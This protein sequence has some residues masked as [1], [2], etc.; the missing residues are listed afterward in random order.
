MSMEPKDEKRNRIDITIEKNSIVDDGEGVIRFNGGLTL[1]DESSQ[2][3]GTRYDIASMDISRYD[4]TV[5]ADHGGMEGYS[6]EK[7]VGKAFGVAKQGTRLIAEG[8]RFAIK[9]SALAR[10]TYDMA[11]NG[12][13]NAV[14]IG[15]FGPLDD[16]YVYRNAVLKEFSFVGLGNNENATLNELAK[17]AIADAES[18]GMDT[19]ELKE[20][21]KKNHVDV[22]EKQE[23][24][25]QSKQSTMETEEKVE[26]TET[27][28]KVETKEETKED[29][30]DQAAQNKILE[31][32]NSL[33]TKVAKIEQNR[34]DDSAEEP[35][36][37]AVPR[38]NASSATTGLEKMGWKDITQLQV[39][40]FYKSTKGD[41]E[42][43]RKLN[44][45]N[46][47][48]F[49][50]L[51]E[52]NMVSNVLTME[53]FGNFVTN[54]ELITTIQ[55]Y[56]SNYSEF[57]AAFPY[58]QTNSLE[59]AWLVRDGDIDMQPVDMCDDGSSGN[60]KPISEYGADVKTKSLEELAA[61]TPVC[62]A[63]TIF[64]AA[65]LLE[66]AG[67]GYRNSYDRNKARGLVAA[68][69]KAAEENDEASYGY[70]ASGIDTPLE[71]L[72]Q[73]R[74]AIFA[75]SQGEGILVMNEASWGIVWSLLT[76]TGNGAAV[77]DAIQDGLVSRNLWT[78][79][80]VIVPNDLMPTLGETGTYK[81][82]AY[83]G[84]TVTINHAVFYINPS[85]VRAREN[86]GLRYDLST[87]AAYEVNGVVRS[88][89]QRNEIVLRGSHF[90][91]TAVLDPSRVGSVRAGNVIS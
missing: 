66:D 35:E 39:V 16:D 72:N 53:D 50:L 84:S 27:T 82:F 13:I 42:A 34:I 62:T 5:F 74:Q 57:L 81:T 8:V 21:L 78:K 10:F 45:I 76:Q 20:F 41:Q 91:G 63:A 17:N 9:E 6:I 73:V 3:N 44:K 55:G 7:I 33:A 12:W 69:E 58:Q 38:K 77:I 24:D 64:M 37:K 29:N 19:R 47:F 11:R 83:E 61:V 68:F 48:N 60:L 30:G 4:G 25:N 85:N 1:S 89:Y 71:Q 18:K 46:E 80:V 54:P 23:E 51:K 75:I 70:T 88:A 22:E 79:R 56:R 67:Q 14:S 15:T 52:K 31:A 59:M 90:R 87:E 2:M 49:D 65:D 26:V 86:G 28:E 40:N 32:I 43:W 36:F